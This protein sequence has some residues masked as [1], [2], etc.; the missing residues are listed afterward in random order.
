[1]SVEIQIDG[2]T[3]GH[4]T[5]LVGMTGSTVLLAPAGVT[6]S[7]DV[8]GGAP[9]TLETALLSPYASV[10]EIHG[11]L[12]TGGS[13]PGLGAASGVTAY[14]REHGYGYQTPFARVPLVVGAVI[15][16]LGVGRS[17]VCPTAADAYSAAGSASR[18]IEEGSVGAGT[19]ATIGK[20]LG[21]EGWMRGGLGLATVKTAGDVTVAALTVVNA[22]G[23]VVA[24]DGTILAGARRDGRFVDTEELLLSGSPGAR[25]AAPSFLAMGNTTLSVV[26]TDARLTKLQCGMVAR[27]AHDGMAR[28]IRP[29]HTPVDGDTI[30]V[31]AAGAKPSTVLHVGSAAVSAV[32]ASIRRAVKLATGTSQ[33]PAYAD[34]SGGDG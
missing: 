5:D 31:L 29:V 28:A 21:D 24:D 34:V 12:L 9:G 33:V 17:D 8:R 23:D 22:L 27:M 18:T 32:A 13:A 16:D 6:A 15:Y 4:Y 10:S 30:F 26:M 2:I 25:F 14:L 19:G 11:L 3:V 7:V 1:M 20:I